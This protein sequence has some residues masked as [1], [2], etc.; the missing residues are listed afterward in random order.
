MPYFN[1]ELRTPT[2][3]RLRT[4]DQGALYYEKALT[5][6]VTNVNETPTDI[7]LSSSSV[8]EKSAG[9]YYK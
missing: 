2:A 5:I 8:A 1:Y 7:S 9:E 4:T 3:S 6:T